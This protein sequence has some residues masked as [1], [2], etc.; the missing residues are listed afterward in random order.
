LQGLLSLSCHQA[1]ERSFWWGD[2]PLPLCTRCLGIYVG[3]FLGLLLDFPAHI[4]R[5]LSGWPLFWGVIAANC[6]TL[7]IASIDTNLCR[8]VLGLGFGIV[9]AAAGGRGLRRS[10]RPVL[11]VQA[12]NQHPACIRAGD[13][14]NA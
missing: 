10:L 1:V 7:F 2:Y 4:R 6:L 5:V 14:G 12:G 13:W 8:L 3:I 9:C 11:E